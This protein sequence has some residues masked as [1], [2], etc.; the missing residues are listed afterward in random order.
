[1]L[2][3]LENELQSA[4]K[5]TGIVDITTATIRQICAL[6]AALEK[7]SGEEFVHLEIG[8]PGLPAEMQGIEAECAALQAGVANKYPDVAGIPSLKE[9]GHNFLKAFLDIDVPARNVIP[10]VGSM[11]GS[12]TLDLLLKRRDPHKDTILIVNPGF[13]AQRHQAK[14]LDMEIAEFD[15]YDYRGSALRDKLEEIFSTGRVTAM[16]YSNPNNPAW[17]NF[18]EEELQIIGDMATLY[19]VVVIEDMAYLGMDFREYFGKP[20]EAPF[21]P[22]VARYTDNYV[23]L[24]SAS[25]IFSYAGQR[26]AMVCMG[27]AVYNSKPATVCDFFEMSCFGDAYVY[28]ILY[29][30]SSG[31]AHSAQHAMAAMLNAAVAGELDFVGHCHE[32]ADRAKKIKKVFVDNGFHIVY[33]KDVDRDISDGFF[34]TVGYGDMDSEKL[35]RALM[36]YGVSSISL[37]TTGSEQNGIRACVSNISRE[38]T[39]QNLETRLKAFNNEY[40]LLHAGTG[41]KAD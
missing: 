9:A 29:A 17:T 8:N 37:P 4:I 26:I 30:C 32:Y 3:I 18:T 33:D 40:K 38:E 34:F 27:E 19:D 28:G 25:K 10:T 11:Q 39:L 35:Q 1:M 20:Y 13:P 14:I 5:N 41:C 21:I 12:F 24:V 7:M 31:T 15:I 2:P 36:R 23:L 16:V 6:A 22:T